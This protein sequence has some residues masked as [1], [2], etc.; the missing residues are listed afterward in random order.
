MIRT[1]ISRVA[2]I[3]ACAFA[4]LAFPP[5][6]SADV[7]F[8]FNEA[9]NHNALS[10]ETDAALSRMEAAAGGEVHRI[11]VSWKDVEQEV[12]PR[13]VVQD[14]RY[15]D[16]VIANM[17]RAGLRPLIVIMKAPDWA[18]A[19]FE[20]QGNIC[21]PAPTHLDDWARFAY[22][23]TKRYPQAVAVEVW[24]EPNG[25]GQWEVA[26]GPD[27][28]RYAQLFNQ[29]AGAIHF[30]DPSMPVLV[31]SVTYWEKDD[32]AHMTIPKFLEGFYRAGGAAQLRPGDG[33]GLHA[34]PWITELETL[35]GPFAKI[36]KQMRDALA[37]RDPRRPIWI[38]ETGVTT[39]GRFAVSERAQ[40][41][42]ILTLATRIPS[43]PDVRALL[44]HSTIESP[45]DRNHLQE[46]GYGL[47]DRGNLAPTLAYCALAELAATPTSATGCEEGVL[48]DLG[49]GG[50]G[51]GGGSGGG[52]G[53]SGGG[54][55]GGDEGGGGG[56]SGGGDGTP[57]RKEAKRH[58]RAKL[59]ATPWWPYATRA[60]RRHK[61]RSCVRRYVRSHR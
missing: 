12:G 29:A 33:I 17:G 41:K 1:T 7:L 9:P 5:S 43:M 39:T 16:R 3:S 36:M 34:Y 25:R 28:A 11:I 4:L 61:M 37:L 8:G 52:G 20:C 15:Y 19:P 27:P 42:G 40:A 60:E 18:L 26:S 56:D 30:A 14:W 58:C 48:A 13:G 49:Y 24:N 54:G 46:P 50:G 2:S 55:G 10:A 57:L 23:V 38:T 6:A 21:P 47:V 45:F 31:G 51:G 53:G 32:R 35:D 22:D 44:I 59:K